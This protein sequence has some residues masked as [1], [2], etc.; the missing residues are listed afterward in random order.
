MKEDESQRWNSP[1]VE[2]SCTGE[3]EGVVKWILEKGEDD[4]STRASAELNS[5]SVTG[6]A[7]G[8]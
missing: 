7:Q 1:N 5:C 4:V 8:C 6:T 3:L 2:V